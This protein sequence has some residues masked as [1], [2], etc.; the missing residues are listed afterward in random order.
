MRLSYN[1]KANILKYFPH[2]ELS[3]EKRLHKKVQADIYLTI[4]KGKK[5]LRG[6]KIIK[7]KICVFC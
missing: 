1:E 6:L 5:F 3:Y 7:T 2:L 4:P